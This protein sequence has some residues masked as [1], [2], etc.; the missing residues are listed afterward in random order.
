[1][2][3]W[4]CVSEK[5]FMA[6]LY[7]QVVAAWDSRLQLIPRTASD[8]GTWSPGSWL[9]ALSVALLVAVG[10]GRRCPSSF[11][12]E[13]LSHT[14]RCRHRRGGSHREAI[15]E[16]VERNQ[17]FWAKRIAAKR[18]FRVLALSFWS[19]ESTLAYSIVGAD[20][21]G[22]GTWEGRLADAD[23]FSSNRAARNNILAP[24]TQIDLRHWVAWNSWIPERREKSVKTSARWK[25][26]KNSQEVA[27]Q[28]KGSALHVTG[29]VQAVADDLGQRRFAQFRQLSLGEADCWVFVLVPEIKWNF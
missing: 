3:V 1:M 27:W 9:L 28:V 8:R 25:N 16:P 29:D 26:H 7:L 5:G 12:F 6:T 13:A 14:E 24:S 11:G 17:W 23:L 10:G 4:V 22:A 21:A 19:F 2:C 15:R 20:A 18:K